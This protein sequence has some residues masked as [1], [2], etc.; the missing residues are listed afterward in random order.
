MYTVQIKTKCTRLILNRF[1][2]LHFLALL[3][4]FC[5]R[6]GLSLTNK[7]NSNNKYS[8]C[9]NTIT[10]SDDYSD[11][12]SQLL[13]DDSCQ[14]YVM[15]LVLTTSNYGLSSLTVVKQLW[16]I[17]KLS[18]FIFCLKYHNHVL[19]VWYQIWLGFLPSFS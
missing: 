2:L 8:K 4:V 9:I 13:Q 1:R 6:S 7:F 17:D 10:Y 19:H 16:V 11:Q 18:K 14:R 3:R 15:Y 5:S 12:T